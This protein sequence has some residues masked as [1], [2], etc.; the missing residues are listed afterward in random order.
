[1]INEFKYAIWSSH[2]QLA[3]QAVCNTFS[4]TLRLLLSTGT[5]KEPAGRRGGAENHYGI[6]NAVILDLGRIYFFKTVYFPK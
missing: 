3:R 2:L 1:M 5:R 4:I 6:Q